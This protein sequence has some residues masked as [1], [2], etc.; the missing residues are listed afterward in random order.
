MKD[1]RPAIAH[2]FGQDAHSPRTT[3]PQVLIHHI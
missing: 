1:P 2:S 3:Q